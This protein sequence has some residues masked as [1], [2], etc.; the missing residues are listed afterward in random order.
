M[1]RSVE[2]T[3]AVVMTVTAIVPAR[4][5]GKRRPD[6]RGKN[7]EGPQGGERGRVYRGWEGEVEK[8]NSFF[9]FPPGSTRKKVDKIAKCFRD[10]DGD[11]LYDRR[12]PRT[13]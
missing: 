8:K 4:V 2:A 1:T 13:G 5:D 12:R 9:F 7:S 10:V 11:E 3:A 6:Q